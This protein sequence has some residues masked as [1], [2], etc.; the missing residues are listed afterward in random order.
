[1]TTKIKI[2]KVRIAKPKGRPIQLRYTDPQTKREVRIT[3]ETYDDAAAIEEKS[4]LEAKLLLGIE[5][6]PKRRTTGPNMAWADFRERYSELQLTTLR[7]RSAD[8]A[9]S[10]LDIAERILKPRT[11]ADVANSEALHDLQARLLAGEESNVGPKDKKR[12]RGP[13]S[14]ITVRNYMAT[15]LAALHWAE[16]MGW[17]PSVPKLRKIKVAKLRQM[18]GRPICTEEF[19]KMLAKVEGEVGAD[20]KA[21][22]EYLLRGLWE[23]GL[24]LDELMHVHWS[25]ARYIMPAWKRGSLP[26]LAIPAAMQKNDTEESIPLLPGFEAL[27]LETKERERFGWVF[28]PMSLQT[29]LG[30]RVRHQRPDA[31]WVGKIITRIGK[32]AGV[33][34]RPTVGDKPPKYASAHDLRRSCAERLISAGVP[35]REVSRVLRHASI[36]TT[37]KHYA[38][39]NVQD[40][41]GIIRK[42]LTVPR[43]NAKA[44]ST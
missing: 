31:E 10:Q 5:A 40:S 9:E 17:L 38:P 41:A 30:R 12:A 32:A 1:M 16:Y 26:V 15:I 27:L 44:K 6:K 8:F 42:A 13:R 3:T 24:R 21:S 4:K 20:A 34:V 7:E 14:P 2:P 19:E 28:N 39:G 18:K 23:S 11:L 33:I 25:D 35:E 22:W 36:E 37:R 43:Y 29:M